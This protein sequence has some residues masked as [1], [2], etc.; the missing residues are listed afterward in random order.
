[1]MHTFHRVCMHNWWI[2]WQ[3]LGDVLHPF[4]K[5][6]ACTLRLHTA[7]AP[8][9][10]AHMLTTY[11]IDWLV[12]WLVGWLINWLIGWSIDE[13]IG[14]LIDWLIKD[15]TS[16]LVWYRAFWDADTMGMGWH[17]IVVLLL[18]Y[19]CVCL[20][21]HWVHVDVYLCALQCSTHMPAWAMIYTSW[22]LWQ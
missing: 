22:Q 9:T 11:M 15:L 2:D 10:T 17:N 5:C 18:M 20:R 6:E 4:Q 19:I 8:V 14:W 7:T 1:M 16:P 3:W 12:G 21:V 13:S